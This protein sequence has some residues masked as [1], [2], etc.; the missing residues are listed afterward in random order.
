ME[1]PRSF[2]DPL[3]GRSVLV[4]DDEESIRMLLEEGLSAQGLH[5]DCSATLKEAVQL[6][7]RHSYDVLLCDLNLSPGGSEV[8]GREAA[9]NILS[10]AGHHKP[11][12]I[13][14]TGDLVGVQELASSEA[15]HLQ[16]PFRVSEVLAVL[17]DVFAPVPAGRVQN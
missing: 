2:A 17:R 13:F 15:R 7:A 3:K 9:Q 10:S 16:K 8:G 5:V 11:A 4:L 1:L 6:A 14:M 12:V